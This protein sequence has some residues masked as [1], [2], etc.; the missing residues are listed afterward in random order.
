MSRARWR[1]TALVTGCLMVATAAGVLSLV[2]PTPQALA[3]DAGAQILD[4]YGRLLYQV[5]DPEQGAVRPVALDQMAPSLVQ[6]TIATEDASFY[7]NPGVDL[8]AAARALKQDLRSG[9][10]VEGGSTITQQLARLRYLPP[11]ERSQQTLG[12]KV[13]EAALALRLTASLGKRTILEQYLNGVP[14]GNQAVG[15][16]AAAQTIFGKSARDLSLAE[17]ALLAG[18][19]Q[20]PADYDPFTHLDA[21]RARQSVVLNLMVQ[22]GATTQEEGDAAR[23]EPLTLNPVPYPIQAP[24][25]VQD[26]RSQL[27]AELGTDAVNRGGLRV[28]TTLDL[29]LQA[30]AERAVRLHLGPLREQNVTDGAVVVVDPRTGEVLAMVG[31]ADYFGQA[32]GAQVNMVLAARQ[33]GSAFKPITY[34]AAL[35]SGRASLAT[36][37]ND[38]RTVFTTR[39]GETYVPLDYDHEF[40]GPVPLR[41]ALA[42]SL[43]VPAVKV[44]S[45][46]GLDR[47]VAL[48]RDMGL[49]TLD[50]PTR[51]DL[52][53][54]LGGGEVR[55]LDL[56]GAYGAF[57]TGGVYHQPYSILRVEDGQGREVRAWAPDQGQRVLS[58]TTA[59][60]ISDVLADDG[61]R[62]LGFGRD[63]V[64]S[65]PGRA[66]AVKTGTTSDWRDNWTIGYTPQVVVGVWVGNADN[67]AMND[68]SGVSGAGPIWHDVIEAAL[69]EQPAHS[70]VRPSGLTQ[71]EL[72]A[73]TEQTA[74]P[75]CPDHRWEWL[76][77]EVAQSLAAGT[78]DAGGAAPLRLISPDPGMVVVAQPG[79]PLSAQQLPIQATAEPGFSQVQLYAD[80]RLLATL[81]SPPFVIGWPISPGHHQFWAVAVGPNLV[82]ATSATV[83]V[84]VAQ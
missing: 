33:P 20:A 50:D 45:E 76:P 24:Y 28:W 75:W 68:V 48:A 5:V 25:F 11:D 63:S 74:G 51:Y 4:R 70:F 62:A 77:P 72:C 21:A 49:Q 61:A 3:P 8:P 1:F 66:I 44:L 40:H 59:W 78:A 7:S 30:T 42:S 46:V 36:V 17:A 79:I 34:A 47:V 52:S 56:T 67:Q 82:Q 15:A 23:A 64:L 81:A 55:L 26:V 35:E 19:P 60:S 2:P 27:E 53:L 18:L 22:D 84:D 54:T 12:R 39:G 83:D 37:L 41:V 14:Y 71:V 31:G 13:D 9:G 69:A 80:G 38:E 57:A 58:E 16:E 65:V 43:N 10:I 32:P 6:A 73:N 29:D